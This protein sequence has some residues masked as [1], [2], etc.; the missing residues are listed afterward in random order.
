M[1]EG[2]FIFA[3]V[4]L[5]PLFCGI[6]LKNAQLIENSLLE[7]RKILKMNIK[8]LVLVVVE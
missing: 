6:G 3:F 7:K 8:F 2:V 4:I 1:F 5:I